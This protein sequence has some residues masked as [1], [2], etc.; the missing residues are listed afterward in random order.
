[1]N[2]RFFVLIAALALTVALSACDSDAPEPSLDE[3]PPDPDLPAAVVDLPS[4]PPATAFEIREHNEDGT[5]RVEGVMGN[6]DRYLES[7]VEIRGFVHE[8]LGDCDPARARQRGES[9]PEPHFYIVDHPDEDRRLMVVGYDNDF[10]RQARLNTGGE[11][12][13]KGR[14]RQMHQGFVSTEDGLLVLSALD[15]REVKD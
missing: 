10:R 2:H 5:L 1:M 12:V 4:P 9:C 6:R 3:F 14:Y 13:F 11:H 8:I 7:D 15:D